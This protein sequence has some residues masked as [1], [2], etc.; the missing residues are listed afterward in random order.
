MYNI[1]C[2]LPILLHLHV[3]N[4]HWVNFKHYLK[5]EKA[6]FI[7]KYLLNKPNIPWTFIDDS[8]SDDVTA[9]SFDYKSQ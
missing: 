8:A 5:N 3:G 9:R 6:F 4:R 7:E 2:I 1:T